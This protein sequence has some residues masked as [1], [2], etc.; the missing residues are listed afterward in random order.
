M[1]EN[2]WKRKSKV[3]FHQLTVER[4]A[5]G[6]QSKAGNQPSFSQRKIT[7][8]LCEVTKDC[9]VF[10]SHRRLSRQLCKH[11]RGKAGFCPEAEQA[12]WPGGLSTLPV[13]IRQT[14]WDAPGEKPRRSFLATDKFHRTALM[15]RGDIGFCV[16]RLWKQELLVACSLT[17]VSGGHESTLVFILDSAFPAPV[18]RQLRSQNPQ[19]G[20]QNMKGN[21]KPVQMYCGEVKT[22]S[23]R[24][25][26]YCHEPWRQTS[27]DFVLYFSSH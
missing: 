24:L 20:K 4:T 12:L 1:S 2:I 25:L 5:K 17:Q 15:T 13:N 8:T 11:H 22:S 3:L 14:I 18:L 26:L 27:S 6:T 9:L 23:Q 10:S 16:L 21:Q 19:V 7:R